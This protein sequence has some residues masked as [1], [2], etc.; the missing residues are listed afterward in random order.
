V[1]EGYRSLRQ[2]RARARQEREDRA[3]SVKDVLWGKGRQPSGITYQNSYNSRLQ[4]IQIFVTTSTLL[5][6]FAVEFRELSNDGREHSPSG[7]QLQR[8]QS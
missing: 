5:Q 4:P 7:L 6:C 1:R 3:A 2:V 8:W